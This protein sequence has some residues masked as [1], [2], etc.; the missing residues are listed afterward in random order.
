MG[1][2]DRRSPEG[3]VPVHAGRRE[4]DGRAGRGGRIV[5]T[6]SVSGMLGNCEPGQLRG[7]QGRHL[8]LTRTAAI[9][10]QKQRIT[11]NAIAP[12]AKTRMTED[13]PMF[14][15][16]GECAHAG[17]VA[18]AALFLASDLCA[19]KTGNVLAG[20]RVRRC[21]MYEVVAE[22]REVQGRGRRLDG[23]GDRG[24]LGRD[25]QALIVAPAR[26][27][28]APGRRRALAGAQARPPRAASRGTA[29]ARAARRGA[30]RRGAEPCG[31]ARADRCCADPR[32]LGSNRFR[33]TIGASAHCS[34]RSFHAGSGGATGDRL[35]C[36][37]GCAMSRG[38]AFSSGGVER[39]VT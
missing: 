27:R 24:S 2:R 3:D 36:C 23:A 26:R 31:F 21:Y 20:R 4:A 25:H 37:Y 1:R 6:T 35:C 14:Q 9:E 13:L 18:P 8:R 10:L 34:S 30:A 12:I 38:A 15:T 7:R 33:G 19:D 17:H 11:V 28:R 29:S 39:R 5:N 16:A 32:M 22:P